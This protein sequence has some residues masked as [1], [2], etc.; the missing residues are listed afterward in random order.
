[1]N[2]RLCNQLDMVQIIHELAFY[3]A[4]ATPVALSD[5]AAAAAAAFFFA[6]RFCLAVR[7]GAAVAEPVVGPS[8]LPHGYPV[9][10]RHGKNYSQRHVQTL[11]ARATGVR[12]C[13]THS[14]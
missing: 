8:Q 3:D 14:S 13:R 5:A 6:A 11:L 4:V 2:V 12:S 1:M 9:P 7:G 10:S